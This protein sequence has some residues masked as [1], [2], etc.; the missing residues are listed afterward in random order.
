MMIANVASYIDAVMVQIAD[1]LGL[2][3]GTVNCFAQRKSDA[4]WLWADAAWHDTEPAGADIPVMSHW[5]GGEWRLT[6]TP[7]NANDVY[8]IL[9]ID[10]PVTCYPD[11]R[12]ESVRLASAID[13]TVAKAATAALEATSQ[14]ILTNLTA[15]LGAGNTAVDHNTAA[16]GTIVADS[17]RVMYDGL[18]VDGAVIE[19][20]QCTLANYNLGVR[21]TVKA[22]SET[23]A[24]GRWL[25]PVYI[26]GGLTYTV[27]IYK[28]GAF[29]AFALQVV[30][31]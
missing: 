2:T 17:M 23:K 21:G 14:T 31:P 1:G 12:V 13:A 11:G 29:S 9:C 16:D 22:R 20:Y 10:S 3:A 4:Y 30:L 8:T 24:D 7:A 5:K 25:R 27:V 28:Q 6:H 19:V 18:P 26:D 15:Q